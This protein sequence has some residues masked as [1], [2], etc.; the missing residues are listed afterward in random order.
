MASTYRALAALLSY[1]TESLQAATG[2]IAAALADEAI[3]TAPHLAAIRGFLDMA[4]TLIERRRNADRN[5]EDHRH[6][7]ALPGLIEEHRDMALDLDVAALT[8]ETHIDNDLAAFIET[9]MDWVRER[10][11]LDAIANAPN[12][13]GF[14]LLKGA[15]PGESISAGKLLLAAL[16]PTLVAAAAFLL[17]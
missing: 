5:A 13:A 10:R 2:E 15:F 4:A 6:A 3:V 12:P 16:A 9:V 8:T 1:P 17:V 14:A 11:P 7:D